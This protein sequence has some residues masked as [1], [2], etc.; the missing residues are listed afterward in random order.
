VV[1][2]DF[3][4][5]DIAK[6]NFEF[7]KE[8]T[9]LYDDKERKAEIINLLKTHI[10]PTTDGCYLSIDSIHELRISFRVWTGW[11]YAKGPLCLR[12]DK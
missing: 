9:K 7:A 8:I 6:K 5:Q 4:K 2:L 10:Y 3:Q 12:G 11:D 1:K